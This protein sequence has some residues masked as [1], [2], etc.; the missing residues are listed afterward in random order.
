MDA[1]VASES[2]LCWVR[3]LFLLIG[4]I[5]RRVGCL[6][7]A[8]CGRRFTVG[9]LF[10][11]RTGFAHKAASPIKLQTGSCGQKRKFVLEGKPTLKWRLHL[12]SRQMGNGST[13]TGAAIQQS[14]GRWQLYTKFR[15]RPL[16]VEVFR[17]RREAH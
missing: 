5:H 17:C 2:H 10:T 13:S 1:L 6:W 9:V 11:H 15:T 16:Q 3:F 7:S 4:T 14:S 8:V 12:E